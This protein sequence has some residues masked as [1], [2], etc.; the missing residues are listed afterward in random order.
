MA[1]KNH[2]V[3][4]LKSLALWALIASPNVR[5]RLTLAAMLGYG[6]FAVLAGYQVL[7]SHLVMS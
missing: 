1:G 7:M 2:L 3:V 6:F 4:W 5:A